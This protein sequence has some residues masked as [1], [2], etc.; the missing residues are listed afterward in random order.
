MNVN[1]AL[2]HFI[3]LLTFEEREQFESFD[4]PQKIQEFLDD[5]PYSTSQANRCPIRVLRDREA[6]CL[7]GALFAACAL[8]SIGYPPLIIDLLP[9]PGKDDDHVLAIFKVK[10]RFGAVAKSNFTGLRFREP[11]YKNLRELVM[12]YFEMYFNVHAQKT[13]RAYTRS[14]DLQHYDQKAWMWSDKGVDFIEERLHFLKNIPVID[15]TSA[16]QL[17]DVDQLTYQAGMLVTN[18]A[19]LYKPSQ[20]I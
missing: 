16:D 5:I 20:E 8:R 2:E 17:S 11:V 9:E 1:Q 12:S 10:S 7:D 3:G 4:A 19:G 6:H 18:P 13:L 14:I 15:Q